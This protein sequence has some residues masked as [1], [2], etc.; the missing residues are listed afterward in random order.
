M[1]RYD[2]STR[3]RVMAQIRKSHT[4]LEEVLVAILES[5]RL[6]DY[7]RYPADLPGSPD[8]TFRHKKLAVFLDSCFWHGCP[9]HLRMPK[10]NLAYWTEKIASNRERDRRQTKELRGQGWR[11]LRLWEHELHKP[12]AVAA[13]VRR[14]IEAIPPR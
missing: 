3:S 11:V 12:E 14:V 10:S 4:R 5:N 6:T 7:V 8:F 1:D 9:R 2:K 13:K